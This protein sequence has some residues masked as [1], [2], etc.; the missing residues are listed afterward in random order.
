MLSLYLYV[1]ELNFKNI[2]LESIIDELETL[3][4]M[5]KAV[6]KFIHQSMSK[7]KFKHSIGKNTYDMKASDALRINDVINVFGL[8]DYDYVFKMWNYYKRFGDVLFDDEIFDDFSYTIEDYDD[9]T[10]LIIAKYYLDNLVGREIYPGWTIE[11]MED[12]ITMVEENLMTM[13]VTNGNYEHIFLYLLDLKGNKLAG[14]IITHNE[15]GLG[16]YFSEDIKVSKYAD[17]IDTI[18]IPNPI[19][20]LNDLSDESLEKYFNFI[21]ENLRDEIEEWDEDIRHYYENIKPER[22]G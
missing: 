21:I 1:M 4:R 15:D 10:K 12:P 16:A 13:L 11:M 20:R 19:K 3:T 18:E 22:E 17:I 6:L 9:A 7:E 14:D 8:K 5:D 2:L